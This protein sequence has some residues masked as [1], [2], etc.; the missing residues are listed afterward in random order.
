M[1]GDVVVIFKT[2]GPRV[3]YTYR[4]ACLGENENIASPADYPPQ[5][6]V[7]NEAAV[8][9]CF[10]DSEVFTDEAAARRVADT[11]ARGNGLDSQQIRLLDY[12][13]IYF[14]ATKAKRAKRVF[15]EERG[16]SHW[17]DR[18]RARDR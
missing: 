4:I 9:R 16:K 7:V 3:G 15:Y 2:H 5:D 13:K 17:R 6:S 10:G 12:S 14:P 11:V 18:R 8:V 1:N